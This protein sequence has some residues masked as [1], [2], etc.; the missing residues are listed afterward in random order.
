M[1]ESN[2]QRNEWSAQIKMQITTKVTKPTSEQK[3]LTFHYV[4][5]KIPHVK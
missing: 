4:S 3:P 1:N 2:K 5:H